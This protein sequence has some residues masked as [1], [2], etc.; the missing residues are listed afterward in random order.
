MTMATASLRKASSPARTARP[1]PARRDSGYT[2]PWDALAET[3]WTIA[4]V[5][6]LL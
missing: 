4:A 5:A 2:G 6:S 3:V 1:N